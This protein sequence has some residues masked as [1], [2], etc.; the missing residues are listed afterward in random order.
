MFWKNSWVVGGGQCRGLA[1]IE[2]RAGFSRFQT[3]VEQL[4]SAFPNPCQHRH[5]GMVLSK[6]E[7]RFMPGFPR[8]T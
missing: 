6:D 5:V 8:T 7:V 4:A 1:M 2:L 3:P